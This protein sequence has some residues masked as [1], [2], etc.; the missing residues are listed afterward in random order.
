MIELVIFDCDGVLVDSETIAARVLAQTLT[1]LGLPHSRREA[2]ER[3][4]GLS[5]GAVV[6]KIEAEWKMRLPADFVQL[7]HEKDRA[8]FNAELT[9]VPGVMEMLT[10]LDRKR[11]VASSG[12]IE[13]LELTL[14]VTGLIAHFHPHIFSAEMVKRGKPA[15]DLFLYAADRM[16]TSVRSCLVV[17]DSVAGV[18]A[19]CAAGMAAVGFVGGRHAGPEHTKVLLDAGATAVLDRMER[20]PAMIGSWGAVVADD[21][22]PRPS[23]NR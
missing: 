13:K 11:C 20:L 16:S 3:Y 23:R 7:V 9:A 18:E 8:A 12:A 19:A 6:A 5:M 21:R 17:E 4:T 1:D 10:R 14:G 2:I 15:P 22:H